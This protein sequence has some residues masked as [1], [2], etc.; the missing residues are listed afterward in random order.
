MMKS[1][2]SVSKASPSVGAIRYIAAEN[3]TIGDRLALD[4]DNALVHAEQG[5]L[6]IGVAVESIPRGCVV[7]IESELARVYMFPKSERIK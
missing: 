1:G 7:D 2:A 4:K 6:I 5:M 3:F